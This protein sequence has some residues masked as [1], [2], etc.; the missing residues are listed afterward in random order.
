MPSDGEDFISRYVALFSGKGKYRGFTDAPTVFIEGNGLY[1]VSAVT[2][3]YIVL[4]S[5]P[6]ARLFGRDKFIGE[7]GKRLNIWILGIGKSRITRKSTVAKKGREILETIDEGMILPED[8][9]PEAGLSRIQKKYDASRHETR[10][11]WIQDEISIFFDKLKNKEYM[12]GT[13]GILSRLYDG[14]TFRRETK[15]EGLIEIKYPYFTAFLTSTIYLPT[16]WT[17][18]MIYQ[19]FLNRFLVFYGRKDHHKPLREYFTEEE[20]READ[21]LTEWLKTLWSYPD[22]INVAFNKETKEKYDDFMMRI[23]DEIEKR[24]FGLRESYYG[25][26][27]DFLVKVAPLYRLAR[28]GIDELN[29]GKVDFLV[30]EPQDLERGIFLVN[31]A[32]KGFNEALE[33]MTTGIVSEVIEKSELVFRFI[34]ELGGEADRT[35]LYRR[36]HA[37][38]MNSEELDKAL[39]ELWK[40]GLTKEEIK[41]GRTKSTQII[42]LTEDGQKYARERF[43]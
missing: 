38:G 32:W 39:K 43:A 22:F 10:V 34:V 18:A 37:K 25:A 14:H 5:A 6:D 41:R 27:P 21:E 40:R 15:G 20:L 8:F 35:T 26:L 19:G 24:E 36:A 31:E 33:R 29:K 30:V 3:R 1:V 16:L 11:T 42:K 13:D 7:T 9:T 28:L 17:E 4:P 23:E 12:A 2:G